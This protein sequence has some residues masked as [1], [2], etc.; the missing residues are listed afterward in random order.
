MMVRVDAAGNLRA[1]YRGVL[2]AKTLLIASHLDTVP[3]AGAFD[4]VLGVVMGI[5]LVEQLRGRL[6]PFAVEVIGFAEEEGVRFGRPFLGSLALLGRLDAETLALTDQGGQSV[7]MAIEEFGANPE[8]L[9]QAQIETAT[10][11]GYLEI[12]LEQGPVLERAGAALGVVQAI[13]GQTRARLHF[14]GQANHAGTTPMVLRH[15]ALAAAAAWVSAVEEVAHA[16]DG[17]VGTVGRLEVLPGAGNVIP[18]EVVATLD[19]RHPDDSVRTHTT[20]K[21][22]ACAQQAATERGVSVSWEITLEQSAVLMDDRMCRTLQRAAE[23]AGYRAD[24]MTS[25]AGHDAMVL[26]PMVPST[27]LFVRT[28]GGVSHHPAETVRVEDVEAA[29][30]T[31]IEFLRML[32]LEQ[33]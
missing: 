14:T 9:E 20:T 11:L 2:G 25:G 19:L 32:S 29:L 28:P 7:A 30:G 21:L 33:R 16:T 22:F 23:A 3:N 17:V 1:T 24:L 13:A 4:G 31:G 6:L 15:D 5:A 26:A 12:H 27:M 18:S 10:T 8:A